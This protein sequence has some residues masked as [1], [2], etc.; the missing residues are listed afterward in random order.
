M[1]C[2][3][4]T[5]LFVTCHVAQDTNAYFLQQNQYLDESISYYILDKGSVPTTFIFTL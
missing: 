3:F 2:D 4:F 1:S 5:G